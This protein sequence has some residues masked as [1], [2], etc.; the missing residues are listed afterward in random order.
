[1]ALV[2]S[3]YTITS[4]NPTGNATASTTLTIQ[5]RQS[6]IGGRFFIV[7][8]AYDNAGNQGADPFSSLT[9]IAGNTWTSRIAVLNDPGAANA[10]SVLRIFT[11][12]LANS[13]NT[14]T[15][16]FSTSVTAKAFDIWEIQSNAGG[17]VTYLTGAS[18]TGNATTQTITTS[19][20]STNDIVYAVLGQEG[21]GTRTGDSDTTNGSWTNFSTGFG[22]T[23]GGQEL[24]G[25]LKLVT[26]TGTQTYNPTATPLGDW[27][28]GWISLTEVLPVDSFDPMGR[29][30][31]FGL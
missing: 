7:A 23:T 13:V 31:F 27:C 9:D 10:G 24:I 17:T 21:N 14:L 20:I 28:M 30:G 15:M 6:F 12:Q 4:P 5:G 2:T 25:G 8:V 22:T 26:G 1:M 3:S 29:M 19:S 18:A 11:S 16:T